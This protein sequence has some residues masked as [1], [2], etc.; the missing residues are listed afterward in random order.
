[1]NFSQFDGENPKLW[2]T[3]CEDYFELYDLDPA[4][5]AKFASMNFSPTVGRWL[6]SVDKKLVIVLGMNF[7][8]YCWIGLAVISMS[9]LL[10]SCSTL[11]KW[12]VYLCTLT[13]LLGYG[14]VS[15]L[16]KCS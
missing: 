4:V 16:L 10:G 15:Y 9:F 5:R 7:L 8:P 1:M 11:N 14:S 2:L 12:V 6:Q 3:R 13:N